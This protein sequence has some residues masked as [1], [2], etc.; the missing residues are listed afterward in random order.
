VLSYSIL[1][2]NTGGAFAIDAA[3]QIT[4]ANS[5][6]L[7]FETVPV[8]SL[9]VAVVDAGGLSDTATVSVN[10]NNVNDPPLAAGDAATTTEDATLNV[11]AAAGV[12]ANDIDLEGGAL[13]VTAVEG[14]PADVGNTIVLG[15]GAL[16]RLNANGSYRYDP[17]GAFDWLAAGDTGF[18]SFSYAVSDP[19]GASS[20]ASVTITLS[21]VNDAPLGF[22]SV[23]SAAEDTP[24]VFSSG[25][26]GFADPDSSLQAVTIASLPAQGSL[27]LAGAPVVAGTVVSETQISAGDLVFLAA[28]DQS[29][30]NYTS[31]RVR[32]S[33][34]LASAAGTN[35]V[36]LDVAP[37]NDLPLVA[38]NAAAGSE[39][40]VL[41]LTAAQ[42]TSV[43][44][45]VDGDSLAQIEIVSLPGGGS[46]MLSG[47]PVALNAVI[48]VAQLGNLAFT[49]AANWNGSTLF[50][51]QGHDGTG[52]SAAAANLTLTL[53]PVNDAP[54]LTAGAAGGSVPWGGT[55]TLAPGVLQVDDV[56]NLPAQLVYTITALPSGGT[57]YRAGVALGS[58]GTFTQG[59]IAAGLVSYTHSGGVAGTDS[60][61][62]TVTDGAGGS[63]GATAFAIAL[64]APPP[65][66]PVVV[67]PPP[68]PPPP[69]SGGSTPPA[70]GG[71]GSDPATGPGGPPAD[72]PAPGDAA[73]SQALEAALLGAPAP[74]L[75]DAGAA[76]RAQGDVRA[77]RVQ[78]GQVLVDRS[79]AGYT[80][81]TNMLGPL[82]AST[83]E[84]S[85][86]FSV[87][88]TLLSAPAS[89]RTE[90]DV[91]VE[92]VTRNLR[93]TGFV[94]ELDTMRDQLDG[95]I[96]VQ[97]KLVASSV[98]VTGSLSVGYV[99]WLLRGGLLLSSLLSSLPAW[100]AVDPMPVLARGGS[101]DDDEGADEDPLERLFGKAKDR[102][103][104]GWRGKSAAAEAPPPA[105]QAADS[106]ADPGK[107][108]AV[109]VTA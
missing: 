95:K 24:Y 72:A 106:D 109:E 73:V 99:I 96:A 31:F 62:F 45:D 59:D 14:N 85:E 12:L 79:V 88:S 34:G 94:G 28:P 20:S 50:A 30:A 4:V 6:A 36:T 33:D 56:D 15:S 60:F 40:T 46:L 104:G 93:E 13:T 9:S 65:L 100:H 107:G 90:L 83:P 43:F 84:T 17:N 7:D 58:N 82:T 5:A 22:D 3:G 51:W 80:I 91:S 25:D 53:A 1:S 37:V 35:S 67:T 47:A 39:D 101:E 38:A 44:S 64:G 32:V 23:V 57:L 52:Y 41:N 63:I 103:L 98:A 77:Q 42:F 74:Q 102:L 61:S 108:A 55:L 75:N 27:T 76:A 8:F 70:S 29:G 68:P 105:A 89:A 2:G 71:G 81:Y 48:P 21:G 78:F 49:P 10:L 66:P 69:P 18:D 26:F 11:L 16:L 92:S 54:V 19:G 87:A 97:G 86:Q